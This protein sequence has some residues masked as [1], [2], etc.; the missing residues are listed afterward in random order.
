VSLLKS[1]KSS[2][3]V[4]A[5]SDSIGRVLLDSDFLKID[6]V[7]MTD[8]ERPVYDVIME[9]SPL[10]SYQRNPYTRAGK[11][12]P[13]V[14]LTNRDGF[15]KRLECYTTDTTGDVYY[16]KRQFLTSSEQDFFDKSLEDR[17]VIICAMR[18]LEIIGKADL[19]KL[20]AT[21]LR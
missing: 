10:Y 18:V 19:V 17:L 12:K 11:H 2:S 14:V 4:V 1:Y 8:W 3:S 7:Q 20:L 5:D 9:D 21:Q 15:N 6:H 16:I 13:V